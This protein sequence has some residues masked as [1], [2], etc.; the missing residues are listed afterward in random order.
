MTPSNAACESPHSSLPGEAANVLDQY[1]A[2]ARSSGTDTLGHDGRGNLVSLTGGPAGTRNN[3]FDFQNRLVAAT[4]DG[5][6]ITYDYGVKGRRVGKDVGGTVTRFLHAGDME[7]AEYDGAGTLLRRYIPGGSID[8]RVAYIEGSGTA[9]AN[10]EYY[11]ADRLGNVSAL[12]DDVGNITDRYAYDPFGHECEILSPAPGAPCVVGPPSSSGQLFRYTGRKYDPET[13]LY[14]YRARYYWPDGGRFLSTDPVGYNDQ[15]NLYT[16]V[17][18]D[19]LNATDPTG[20]YCNA[21]NMG[22]QFCRRSQRMANLHADPRISSKTTFAAAASLTTEELGAIDN[23]TARFVT[24]PS[25]RA[26]LRESSAALEASNMGM[27]AAI[28]NGQGFSS[29]TRAEND[30]AFVRYEQ[31]PCSGF[32]GWTTNR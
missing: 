2:I 24:S 9:A 5:L 27:F 30:T 29:G 12:S 16:Y 17:A 8:V 4:V 23:F 1:E 13:G 22:S 3:S 28:R 20:M 25:T 18:N 32:L 31:G 26:F 10:I 11:H 14:Y 15:F 6:A 7:I 19:P 21:V